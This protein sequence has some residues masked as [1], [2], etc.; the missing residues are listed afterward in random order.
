MKGDLLFSQ[1]LPNL[2]DLLHLEASEIGQDSSLVSVNLLLKT[3]YGLFLLF[4]VQCPLPPSIHFRLSS[5]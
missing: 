3:G 2:T 1:A 4:A 5:S